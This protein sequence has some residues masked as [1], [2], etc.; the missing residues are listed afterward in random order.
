[1]CSFY[2]LEASILEKMLKNMEKRT[3][4]QVAMAG[5]GNTTR[6]AMAGL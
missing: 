5:L 6:V 1:M 4:F 2:F 3:F